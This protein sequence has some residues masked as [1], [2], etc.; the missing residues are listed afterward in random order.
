MSKKAPTFREEMN[1]SELLNTY[2]ENN[3]IENVRRTNTVRVIARRE[4]SAKLTALGKKFVNCWNEVNALRL[5]QYNRHEPV[6]FRGTE[7]VVYEKFKAILHGANVQ[8]MTRKNAS[9]WIN[10]F[11]MS[12]MIGEGELEFKPKPPRRK[13][14]YLFLLV[15]NDRYVIDGNEIYI[16][17]FKLRLG[18]NGEL[19][20]VGR[21][22]TLEIFYDRVR[23]KW[24]ARVPMTVKL[25]DK[26]RGKM[27]AGIDLGIANLA[28]V[29]VDDGSWM[30]SRAVRCAPN[31]SK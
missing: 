6:D 27:K 24:Y 14:D 18:F 7:K 20:W 28:T 23:R 31:S 2:F 4:T 8:Q 1:C 19:R 10:Y 25:A 3:I 29:A 16:M 17:D 15:R 26:P 11:A 21:R 12:K 5:E 30:L 13:R 9:A 22:G